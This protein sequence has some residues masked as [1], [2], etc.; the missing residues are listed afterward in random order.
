MMQQRC[1]NGVRL[2]VVQGIAGG[3]ATAAPLRHT[4]VSRVAW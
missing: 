2:N 4:E 1:V 3:C